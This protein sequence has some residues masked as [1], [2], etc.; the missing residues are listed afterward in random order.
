MRK[1][2]NVV[3][4]FL[5]A[6]Q[7]R[8]ENLE[9]ETYGLTNSEFGPEKTEEIVGWLLRGMIKTGYLGKSYL[10]FDRGDEDWGDLILT[11]ILRQEPIF[12]YRLNWRPSPTDIGCHWHL[13]EHPSLR[14]YQLHFEAN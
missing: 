3:L 9:V 6:L 2:R 4:A 8:S 10:V 14:L 12:L 5:A 7:P 1:L 11:A 13:T